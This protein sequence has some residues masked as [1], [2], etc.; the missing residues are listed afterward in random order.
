MAMG[1]ALRMM[2]YEVGSTLLI[3]NTITDHS[4]DV[5]VA[6]NPIAHA[7]KNVAIESTQSGSHV[8]VENR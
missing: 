3:C 8:N 2:I 4:R 7:I 6:K 5:V 1:A